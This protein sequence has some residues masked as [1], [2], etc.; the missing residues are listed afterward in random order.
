VGR[1]F[2]Q[3]FDAALAAWLGQ[4]PGL[5]IFEETCGTAL[6]MEHN[7][8]LYACDHFVEP[9]YKLGN[10]HDVPLAEMVGSEPQRQFGQAKRDTL[11]RYCR[12]CQVRFVCNG[13]C[14]KNRI[15][16]TPE[17]EPG[18]N[19]EGEP[20]LSFL[21]AGYKAFFTHIDRPMRMMAAEL[22]AGRPA[23]NVMLQLAQ[24]EAEI[25]R[26]FAQAGRNDPCPCGSGLKFKRC[27]GRPGRY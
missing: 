1:V 22:R 12:E 21:C 15:L 3:I 10:M 11:P 23:A 2:V 9:R 24:E 25:Q 7:G 19:P 17:G 26:R 6:A 13:G 8:D 5:C 14:P 20:G 16:H 4:R 27:H 18:L